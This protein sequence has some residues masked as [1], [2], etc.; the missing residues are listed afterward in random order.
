MYGHMYGQDFGSGW[1][2]LGWLWMGLAWLIPILL[3][4]AL[5][6]YLFTRPKDFPDRKE[7]PE[8]TPLDIVKE[9]YARGELSRE[10][11]LQKVEDLKQD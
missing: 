3:L 1:M 2:L 11:Y 4:L 5:G 10:D 6:K 8:K 7:T 9:A